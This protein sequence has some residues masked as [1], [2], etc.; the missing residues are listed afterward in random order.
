MSPAI[1]YGQDTPC[2]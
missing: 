1:D 2:Q